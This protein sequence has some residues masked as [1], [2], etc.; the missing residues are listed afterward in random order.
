HDPVTSHLAMLAALIG[1]PRVMEA[2]REAIASG[3]RW[4]EFGDSHLILRK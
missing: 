4:H 2:Y 3:Y 1:L